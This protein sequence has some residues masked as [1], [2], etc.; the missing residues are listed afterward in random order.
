MELRTAN[1]RWAWNSFRPVTNKCTDAG[2]RKHLT[3]TNQPC[4]GT[5]AKTAS[6]SRFTFLS[7]FFSKYISLERFG[8]SHNWKDF[9][10]S[11]L[12]GGAQTIMLGIYEV[13][14]MDRNRAL[15][16]RPEHLG[17]EEVSSLRVSA[18]AIHSHGPCPHLINIRV[19]HP[20]MFI[21]RKENGLGQ[22][23][24]AERQ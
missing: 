15:F 16:R 10:W 9:L 11:L 23:T 12:L 17:I 24:A 13:T 2:L 21:C 4:T 1:G 19:R 3:R 20:T 5:R 22:W 7:T 6:L 18:P 8:R 14:H